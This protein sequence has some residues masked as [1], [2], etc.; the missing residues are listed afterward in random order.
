MSRRRIKLRDIQNPETIGDIGK[1]VQSIIQDRLTDDEITNL[2]SFI[3]HQSSNRLGRT[4]EE[5]IGLVSERYAREITNSRR[6]QARLDSKIILSD[7]R[8][9]AGK[10]IENESDIR[11]GGYPR[12]DDPVFEERTVARYPEETHE[13]IKDLLLETYPSRPY[14]ERKIKKEYV[15]LDTRH[16]IRAPHESGSGITTFSWNVST[17]KYSG[18]Q[19]SV[20]MVKNIGKIISM[21][22]RERFKV[23]LAEEILNDRSLVSMEIRE[24]RAQSMLSNEHQAA[25]FLFESSADTSGKFAIL[26]PGDADEFEFSDIFN[27]LDY[28]TISFGNPW[29]RIE[30]DTDFLT[31]TY[32]IAAGVA[33]FTTPSN[34][35][36]STGQ[37]VFFEDF[38]TGD[39]DADANVIAQVNRDS[40]HIVSVPGG[41]NTTFTLPDVSFTG[42]TADGSNISN[43]IFDARRFF[44]PLEFSYLEDKPY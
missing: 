41:S 12:M 43:V 29:T 38:S 35:N 17:H 8:T 22:V 32:T 16:R 31:A 25:H 34:H 18:F 36:L 40:G 1:A 14:P 15:L 11:Q 10:Y 7:S 23:P 24:L 26:D 37:R 3:D 30:F 13:G 9:P 44:V 28:I 21:R 2:V 5:T 19:G 42:V 33:T 6:E 27:I 39:T 20:P 4:M